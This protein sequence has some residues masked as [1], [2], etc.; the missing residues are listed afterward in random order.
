ML[1][2]NPSWNP[3]RVWTGDET[4]RCGKCREFIKRGEWTKVNKWHGTIFH[5]DCAE[6]LGAYSGVA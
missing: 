5:D 6:E 4:Q 3:A 2:T 1:A